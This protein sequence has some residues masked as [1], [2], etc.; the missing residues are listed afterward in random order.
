MLAPHEIVVVGDHVFTDVILALRLTH[1]RAPWTRLIARLA[2]ASHRI[3]SARSQSPGERGSAPLAVRTTGVWQ[4]QS[5]AIRWAK[6]RL[7]HLVERWVERARQR[8]DALEDRFVRSPRS[9]TRRWRWRNPSEVDL[10]GRGI[11]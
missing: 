4:R 9:M 7:V 2:R 5:T 1:P 10:A 6:S 11:H 3:E 8:M